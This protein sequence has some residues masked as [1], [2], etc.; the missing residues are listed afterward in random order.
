M[1]T[2]ASNLHTIGSKEAFEKMLTAHVSARIV[3]D[4]YADWCGPCQKMK[5]MVEAFAQNHPHV[6][7]LVCNV[8]TVPDVA[9]LFK[10]K[11]IPTFVSIHNGKAQHPHVGSFHDAK[12]FEKWALSEHAPHVHGAHCSH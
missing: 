5:P 3:I 4:F 1:S 10:V 9:A 12:A 11:S 2:H 6:V 8:E 7:V